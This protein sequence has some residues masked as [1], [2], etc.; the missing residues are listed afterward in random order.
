M[1]NQP[2]SRV[3]VSIDQGTTNTKAVLV[4]RGRQV[5]GVGSAPVGV[6]SPAPGMGRAGRRADLGERAVARS[7]TGRPTRRAGHRRDRPVHPA[8]VGPRPGADHRPPTRSGHRLAGQPDGRLV[9]RAS[10]D[11]RTLSA[12]GPDCRSTPC[13]PAPKI[14]WLLDHLPARLVPADVTAGTVD[15]WLV[16]HLTGGRLH[17]CDAGNASRTLLFDVVDLAWSRGVARPVR[18]AGRHCCPRSGRSTAL[19]RRP[20]PCRVSPTGLRSWPC[21]P[22]R[23]PRC[24]ARAAPTPGTGEG[25]LRHRYR[26]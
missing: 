6:T 2:G 5:V 21:W 18:G 22:T 20:L 15:A 13:S 9:F 4:D 14:R 24:T 12:R 25:H 19:R 11:A 8:R 3:I 7:P 23:T 10:G 1:P 17:A 26:R 16:W